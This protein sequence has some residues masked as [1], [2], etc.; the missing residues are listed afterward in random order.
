[1]TAPV[2]PGPSRPITFRPQGPVHAG[3]GG[4]PAPL[5]IQGAG[6]P[7]GVPEE[8]E[9]ALKPLRRQPVL[10][11]N[12]RRKLGLVLSYMRQR[13]LWL[14]WQV[15]NRCNFECSFCN[16]WN[17][18]FDLDAQL[19]PAQFAESARKLSRIGTMMVSLAGGE[20]TLRR[21]LP[22]IVAAVGR[23]HFPFLT[24][25]GWAI[26]EK[27]ARSLWDAGLWGVSISIDYATAH[28]HDEERGREGAFKHAVEAVALLS[29]TRTKPY[30]RVNINAVLMQDN[31]H[32]MEGLIRIAREHNALFMVQPYGFLKTGSRDPMP[33][34]SMSA[35]LLE[36]SQR[37]A[38]FNSN[39]EFLRR[40][41]A[42]ITEG[43]DGCR[44]GRSFFNIDQWGNISKCVE[45]R[46]DSLGRVQDMSAEEIWRV[47]AHA[48]RTN[49]CTACWYN[50][51]GEIESLYT[52]RGLRTGLPKLFTVPG[53]HCGGLGAPGAG[54]SE[55][56]SA[57]RSGS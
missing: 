38:N 31:L 32:E 19:T 47:L 9:T 21:D 36:L 33:K 30:Q 24:T 37:Y 13:P 45:Y 56:L 15:T 44:A 53:G 17:E 48:H 14:T 4:R 5:P 7:P 50:C 23:W 43:V 41:D 42:H 11:A 52:L 35:H 22:E 46:E 55:G 54:A 20:P 27:V 39:P 10:L 12:V 18:P 57:M 29:R 2:H 34:E 51:R 28:R 26:T 16:Y 40:F 25:N 1:M 8:P 6:T 49:E 3:N